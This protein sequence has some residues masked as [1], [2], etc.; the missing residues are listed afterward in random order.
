[1]ICLFS[2]IFFLNYSFSVITFQR[3][4]ST[5]VNINISHRPCP[6]KFSKQIEFYF[7]IT[8][9]THTHL[10]VVDIKVVYSEEP[11]QATP[12]II[13]SAQWRKWSVILASDRTDNSG[14]LARGSVA[15]LHKWKSMNRKTRL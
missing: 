15:D 5:N 11:L 12:D 10:C 2:C 8:A 13:S 14:E 6:H 1:M 3:K 7:F 4:P 9:Q